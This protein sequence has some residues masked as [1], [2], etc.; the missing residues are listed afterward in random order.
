MKV[1]ILILSI[2]LITSFARRDDPKYWKHPFDD[3]SPNLEGEDG[4]GTEAWF[5]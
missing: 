1:F 4:L 3:N 2:L 5:D